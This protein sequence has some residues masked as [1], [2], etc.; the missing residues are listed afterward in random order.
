MVTL[1]F[2]VSASSP[3]EEDP[4]ESLLA[5]LFADPKSFGMS[6]NRNIMSK[7]LYR[8]L[9]DKFVSM[10]SGGYM[11]DLLERMQRKIWEME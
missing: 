9:A 3:G 10:G 11:R 1:R 5:T 6:V 2:P 7:T 4:L 8:H